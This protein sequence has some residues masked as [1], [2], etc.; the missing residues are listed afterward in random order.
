M[1]KVYQASW[2][3]PSH[4]QSR[5]STK[6][7]RGTTESLVRMTDRTV[8]VTITQPADLEGA[9][10]IEAITIK[11]LRIKVEA[12]ITAGMIRITGMI[13]EVEEEVT[14]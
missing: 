11:G 6:T 1:T 10:A 13:T 2:S 9:E 4:S 8:G 3:R 7:N 5:T 14:E 12:E